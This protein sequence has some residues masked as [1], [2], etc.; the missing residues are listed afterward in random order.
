M[1]CPLEF[2]VTYKNSSGKQFN[3]SYSLDFSAFS[4]LIIGGGDPLQKIE[5]HLDSVQKQLGRWSTGL[6]KIQVAT[7]PRERNIAQEE[8]VSSDSRYIT[9]EEFVLTMQSMG[10]SFETVD[11]TEGASETNFNE[12]AK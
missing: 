6:H 2:N 7:H 12:A 8:D 9:K 4:E 5:K 1:E 10:I 11:S 3:D